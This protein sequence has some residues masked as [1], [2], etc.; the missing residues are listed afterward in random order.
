[1]KRGSFTKRALSNWDLVLLVSLGFPTSSPATW[2]V[3]SSHFG[4]VGMLGYEI[5]SSLWDISESENSLVS[6]LTINGCGG[7]EDSPTSTVAK[8]SSSNW[9]LLSMKYLLVPQDY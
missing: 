6:L 7:E 1:M 4:L 9:T 8:G 5:N 3:L 2:M